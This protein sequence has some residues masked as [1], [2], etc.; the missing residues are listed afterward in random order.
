MAYDVTESGPKQQGSTTPKN[1]AARLVNAYWASGVALIATAAFL[2]SCTSL[3]VKL[4]G[5]EVP[6]FQVVLVPGVIC[7]IANS[8]LVQLYGLSVRSKSWRIAGLTLLRG[9]LGATSI[10]CFYLAIDLLPLQDA[11]TLFFCSPVIAALLEPL[12]VPEPPGGVRAQGGW[13]G[14][15]ATAATVIGVVLVAQPESLF[16]G[17]L[18]TLPAPATAASAYPAFPAPSPSFPSP[19][20]GAA[21]VGAGWGVAAAAA[22]A[23]RAA[24]AAPQQAG[25]PG[26]L[27]GLAPAVGRGGE[28]RWAEIGLSG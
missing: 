18:P 2:F 20:G 3:A 17:G 14:A 16:H 4:L 28:G 11:V 6:T 27:A 21:G 23:A 8:V 24:A 22:A 13:A 12:L 25:V 15:A 1:A 9:L 10:I 19:H 26:F 7:F 5:D